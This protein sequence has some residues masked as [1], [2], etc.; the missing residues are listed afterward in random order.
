MQLAP[1]SPQAPLAAPD[2]AAAVDSPDAAP[3]HTASL[4]AAARPQA[5]LTPDAPRAPDPTLPAADIAN[6]FALPADQLMPVT[7]IGL[8]VQPGDAWP[9]TR[10]ADAD[11]TRRDARDDEARR[12]PGHDTDSAPPADDDA[13]DADHAADDPVLVIDDTEPTDWLDPLARAINERLAAPQP[14]AALRAAAEQWS[15]A[16]CVVLVCPRD[17]DAAD[18]AWACVLWPRRLARSRGPMATRFQ[19]TGQRFDA[20]LQWAAPGPAWCETRA[21]KD[22]HPRAGRRLVA[23]DAVGTPLGA[24]SCELQ[25]GPVRIAPPRW[26]LAGV[27]IDAVRRFWSAIG[28][29]WSVLL[30]VSPQAL[31]AR[32]EPAS[33]VEAA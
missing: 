32:R 28:G 30:A 10:Q 31:I 15:R 21:I 23:L 1:V 33:V 12:G 26:K 13:D 18:A 3:L 29:Q 22:H 20:R 6:G 14:P 4:Q 27:R 24:V 17:D 2:V 11:L 7:L 9:M 16:R 19:F 8:Q 5:V 25:L